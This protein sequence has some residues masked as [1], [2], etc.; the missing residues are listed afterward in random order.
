[1][2]VLDVL[3]FCLN[4]IKR[5]DILTTN[6]FSENGDEPTDEQKEVVNDLKFCLNDAIQS[7][8]Y[9]YHPLKAY[10]NI[11]VEDGTFSYN[12]LNKTLI[13]V[14]RIKDSSGISHHF[15]TYPTY[16]K[17]ENGTYTL[18]YTY[19]PNLCENLS[20]TID[21]SEDKITERV[22]S[23]GCTSQFYLKRG[24]FKESNMWETY[25]ERL[26]SAA[27]YPKSVLDMPLRRWN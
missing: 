19:Q 18:T 21:L 6:L 13:D 15:S 4:D 24:M 9:V 10:E 1:M 8:A 20:D 25:F 26:I 27:K 2:I 11:V 14:I 23:A 12:N 7:I 22:L 3:K 5:D 17:C 16:F